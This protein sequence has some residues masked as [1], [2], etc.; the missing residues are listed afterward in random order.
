VNVSSPVLRPLLGDQLTFGIAS[1]RGCHPGDVILMAEVAEETDYVP[2]HPQKLVLFL[3]AMRHFARSLAERG[4]RVRYVRLDDP[5]NTGSIEGEVRRALGETGCE[6]VCVTEPG[7]WRLAEAMAQWHQH[8]GVP[9]TVLEDDRF[10]CSHARFAKWS[11][12]RT[13][14]RMEF[15]YREMRRETGLLMEPDGTPTGG[16]WNYDSENRR[17]YDGV[18][19]LPGC[20]RF[21][22]DQITRE[23]MALVTQRFST[24]FGA[25][26]C[27][28]WP[29]T[30]S[31]AEQALEIFIARALPGFG[32]YQDAMLAS[33]DVLFHS[34]LSAA[35]NLGLLDPLN[36]CRA[37]EAAWQRGNAPLNA[38]EGFIRQILGWREFIRGVYWQFMPAYRDRNAL[39]ARRRLPDFFWGAPTSMHCVASVVE[40][41]RRTAYAHHIQRLMVT[42]NFALLAGIAPEAVAEW[43]LAVYADA[44]EWVELPNVL[45]MALHAD[46]GLVGSKPYCASGAYINRMSDYCRDCVHDHK[47]R[48]GEAACPFNVL[49]WD[50][51]MRHES[52][53]ARNPRMAMSYRNL[54]RIP[55]EERAAIRSSA[56]VF[57]DACAPEN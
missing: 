28:D 24:R 20:V 46:G 35:I 33:E 31:D 12:G 30:Q 19:A 1:L 36:V 4:L 17:R 56:R 15:F 40:A 29:V 11:S 3:S 18:K 48:S 27:F 37:A 55:Q 22:P 8:L 10:L 9:V 44:V 39:D 45:G 50:F 41:T 7:E 16:Q 2:H 38:A 52:S 23:V 51:L 14:L 26:D 34:R 57:L 5:A 54:A 47:R 42:G 21:V 49:Y 32:D 6:A 43:Y 53:L 25:L 13:A